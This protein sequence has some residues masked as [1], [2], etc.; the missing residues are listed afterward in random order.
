[1]SRLILIRPSGGC[2]LLAC[3]VLIRPSCCCLLLGGP[4]LV[5]TSC[6]RRDVSLRY[7][8]FRSAYGQKRPLW[9]RYAATEEHARP[10]ASSCTQLMVTEW[11]KLHS[12]DRDRSATLETMTAQTI[13]EYLE[14][15]REKAADNQLRMEEEAARIGPLQHGHHRTPKQPKLELIPSVK[16]ANKKRKTV[17]VA[18]KKPRAARKM[19][20]KTRKRA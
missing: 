13:P 7:A 6:R 12:V 17:A 14:E 18:R 3:L 4:V 9:T 1:M 20:T 5:R 15:E 16:A 11:A 10:R 8:V 2:L 19:A